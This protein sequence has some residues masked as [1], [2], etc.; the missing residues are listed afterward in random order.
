MTKSYYKFIAL[1]KYSNH[2]SMY[3]YLKNVLNIHF[4]D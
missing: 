4:T 2:Y 3:I 1:K